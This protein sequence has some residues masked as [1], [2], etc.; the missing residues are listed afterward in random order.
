[1]KCPV[2]AAE[3]REYWPK[4]WGSAIE[5]SVR[6]CRECTLIFLWPQLTKAQ[7]GE[8]DAKYNLYVQEREKWVTTRSSA[9]VR[10]V[11][12]E[13]IRARWTDLAEFF[14]GGESLMEIGAEH[15]GFLD[16]AR[17]RYRNVVGVDACPEYTEKLAAKGFA[18]FR[19][20]DDVPLNQ[21][22]DRI[23]FFSL[24]EHVPDPVSFLK[25][26][27]QRLAPGGKAI[28]EVPSATEPLIALYDIPAFKD[29]YFQSMHP[30]VFGPRSLE[31]VL[32]RAG[33][34]VE[35]LKFKQRYGLDNHLNWLERGKPGGSAEFKKVL[36]PEL[37]ADYR[38]RLE[39]AGK[40]DMLYAVATA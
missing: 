6:E 26:V 15:G 33:L 17:S 27:K 36:G 29:F 32:S 40:S 11:V 7:Q 16:V 25:S 37:D 22:F 21:K 5:Q 20:I 28:I 3:S 10:D 2:C 18:A 35:K 24:L 12:D 34:K 4:V 19:Y 8:F 39:A 9:S 30:Y 13:S 1:M 14:S 23:C 38:A 31:A